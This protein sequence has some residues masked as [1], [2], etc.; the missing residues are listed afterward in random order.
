MLINDTTIDSNKLHIGFDVVKK[1]IAIE[2]D[3]N[4]HKTL[5]TIWENLPTNLGSF[6]CTEYP[7]VIG[8]KR[9]HFCKIVI[10]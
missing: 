8:G 2:K 9:I 4:E 5:L 10:A 1:I 3:L 7:T 6:C